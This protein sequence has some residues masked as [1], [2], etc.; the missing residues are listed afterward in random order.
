M[1]DNPGANSLREVAKNAA[2]DTGFLVDLAACKDMSVS[3]LCANAQ[4]MQVLE[5]VHQ[6]TVRRSGEAHAAASEARQQAEFDSLK[7][8]FAFE[9]SEPVLRGAAVADTSP[10]A[11]FSA[12]S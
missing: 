3:W 1:P 11:R 5:T 6:K 12:A 9:V 4:P 2:K 10:V 8:F 7:Q